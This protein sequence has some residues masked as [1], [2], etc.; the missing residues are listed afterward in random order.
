M[1]GAGKTHTMIG[2]ILNN[3]FMND[4]NYGISE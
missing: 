3:D 2:N 1:T 4:N